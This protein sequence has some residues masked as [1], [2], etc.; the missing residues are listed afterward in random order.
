MPHSPTPAWQVCQRLHP[1]SVWTL[2]LA[3]AHRSTCNVSADPLALPMVV[4]VDVPACEAAGTG[5]AYFGLHWQVL[6]CAGS[7]HGLGV[8]TSR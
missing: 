7:E 2:P 6:V 5:T 4:R 8:V 3:A 1:P